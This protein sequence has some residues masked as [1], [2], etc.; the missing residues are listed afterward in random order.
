MD[1]TAARGLAAPQQGG[2]VIEIGFAGCTLPPESGQAAP[3]NL[4]PSGKEVAEIALF[5]DTQ[6]RY[7]RREPAPGGL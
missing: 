4:A 6:S 2:K 5:C 3:G 7:S 1:A